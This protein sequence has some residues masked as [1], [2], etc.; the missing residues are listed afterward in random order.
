MVIALAEFL[1]ITGRVATGREWLHRALA[2]AAADDRLTAAALYED[3][4]L[5][6]WQG[7]HEEARSLHERSLDL[8]RRLGDQTVVAQA[9]CG[10]ARVALREDLDRGRALCEDALEV[11]EGTDDKWGRSNALHVLG[12]TAQ[13]RGD[14]QGASNLMS[15]RIQLARELGDFAATAWS[16]RT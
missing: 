14:L 7:A 9:L 3:G 15:H 16:R 11:V 1:R 12:A 2:A 13:M 8:A 6:F 10:L 5:A 4:L